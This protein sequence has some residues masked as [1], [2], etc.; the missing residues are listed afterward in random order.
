MSVK[1]LQ[2]FFI[3]F[4]LLFIF[5]SSAFS[6]DEVIGSVSIDKEALHN[7]MKQILMENPK[8]V[9]DAYNAYQ[10]ELKQKKQ[11]RILEQSFQNR[12]SDTVE[13]WHPIK[14]PEDAPVTLIM[15][16]DYQ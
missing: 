12:I 7:A 14:G 1:K 6:E 3:C 4:T 11:A 9:Y 8:L 5:A 15:Y 13:D 2:S 16:M 10:K